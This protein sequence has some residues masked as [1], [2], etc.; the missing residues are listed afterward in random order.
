M[1]E[2]IARPISST[3]VSFSD[4]TERTRA[5]EERWALARKLEESN[6]RLEEA[7]R[8]AHVGHWEWDL[9]TNEVVWSDETYRIF[10]LKP[11]ERAMN[12]AAV[13]EMVHP[14]DRESLYG[15]VDVDLSAGAYPVAEF[16]IV[17][18]SGEVRTVHAITSK[19]WS[20]L[21]GDPGK[22][23]SGKTHRLLGTVQEITD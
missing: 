9:E 7:Q 3:W 2:E 12:L 17:R 10:G 21:P 11:Q 13:R 20:A 6:A 23:K 15:G 4:M 8:I 19:L 14:D 5:D 22:G 1:P 18:P 16:R